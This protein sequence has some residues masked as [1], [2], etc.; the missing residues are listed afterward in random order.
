MQAADPMKGF[1]AAVLALGLI[2]TPMA[3]RAADR[4][5]VLSNI[6]WR[7]APAYD[8]VVA[9]YPPRAAK[10]GLGGR[11]RLKC[12]FGDDGW[13]KGCR[14]IDEAPKGLGFA[15]AAQSLA[16]LFQGPAEGSDGGSISGAYT[17]IP[18]SFTPDMLDPAKRPTG[19]AT[20]VA[21]P[22]VEAFRAGFPAAAMQAGV[23]VARVVLRC[24]AGAGGALEGCAVE[25]EEPAGLGFGDA[26]LKLSGRFRLNAWSAEGLPVIGAVVRV[27]L[28]YDAGAPPAD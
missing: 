24:T 18:F 6:P 25:S 15:S 10:A 8:Q 5:A 28:R 11:A 2:A 7:A 26:A 21:L 17:E 16:G 3:A 27:P 19:K 23:G 4:N 22:D 12:R 14:T 1:A 9:A 20:W 13:I